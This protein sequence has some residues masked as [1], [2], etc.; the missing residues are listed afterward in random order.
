MNFVDALFGQSKHLEKA[1]I[2][3][4]A[5]TITYREIGARITTL[6][7]FLKQLLGEDRKIL[8]ISDNSV[9][10]ITAY[11]AIMQSGN[12][13]VP[14]NPTI[15]AG[16]LAYIRHKCQ[17]TLCFAQKKYAARLMLADITV[18][19]EEAI[20]AQLCLATDNINQQVEREPTAPFDDKRVAAILFTSGSTAQPKGVM[21]S[22]ANLKA[23]TASI[24]AYLAL[25]ADDVMAMVLP[26][27]YCY[28]LSVLHTHIKV[29][30][31]LVLNNNFLLLATV[32]EDLLT[33]QCTGFA[34]V[35]SHF[36]I[37][38][39]RAEGFIKTSF[40]HLRYV[41]QAGGKLPEPF[42]CEFLAAFPAVKFY[43][44]YGQTEA[45]ARLSYLPPDALPA[46]L[47]SIGKGIPGVTLQVVNAQGEF[48]QPEEI[49]EIVADGE[50]IMLGYL[51]DEQETRK[52]I[53][54]GK[55]RTGDLA[56]VDGDGY[57]YL[58]ARE[59]EFLKVG[60]E[61][62]SPKEIEEVLVALPDVVDCS[63]VGIADEQLGEAVKAM[64]VL[65]D[66]PG[67][68]L[69]EAD[70][71]TYC[72]KRLARNK[73]PKVIQFVTEIPMNATGKKT[74]ATLKQASL[75]HR[76]RI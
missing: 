43:A 68:Q 31:S 65:K 47:G 20:A 26:F 59:K 52:V 10:F 22:H 13:V 55:L 44:M 21:L 36:Q 73:I 15:E 60:G 69:T 53:Q 61:R 75:E 48:I 50:N 27:F 17:A 24:L 46:K 67:Q 58:V 25:T 30:G 76:E 16:K 23:N 28:G 18:M 9:F 39:R 57:I 11:F 37:L 40:P 71:R 38:L 42:I 19:D 74:Q 2:L 1:L 51:E 63:V 45:T 3:G 62:I 5:E 54:H 29:G 49:G 12:I 33:Y 35:P 6:A 41:T 7:T 4:N 14:L 72:H 8:L 34:G 64:L 32:I 66:Q 70:I 56:T